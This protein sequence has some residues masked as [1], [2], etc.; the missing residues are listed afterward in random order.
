MT[1]EIYNQG[2]KYGAKPELYVMKVG[3]NMN[4]VQSRIKLPWD[5]VQ[6]FHDMAITKSYIILNS[7]PFGSKNMLALLLMLFGWNSLGNNLHWLEDEKS[8]FLVIDRQSLTL[9]ATIPTEPFSSYHYVN[10][11]DNPDGTIS[12][13]LARLR[14]HRDHLEDTFKDIFN[15]PF[16]SSTSSDVYRYELNPETSSVISASN[17][18]PNAHPM[19]FPVIHEKKVGQPFRYYF[20]PCSKEDGYFSGYQKVDI[21]TGDV[22]YYDLP[23]G[24]FGNEL[25]FI[26]S[27]ATGEREDEG[28]LV[29]HVYNGLH[30]RSEILVLDAKTMTKIALAPLP[31]HIPYTFHGI[32]ER[33]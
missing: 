6:M 26:S 32:F 20:S 11:Y 25:Q 5:G 2:Q 22:L 23:E 9:K 31:H 3:S 4:L 33:D 1:N 14:G 7:N 12:V 16:T 27:D 30:H 8:Y 10:A 29:T 18:S 19:E 28:Y 13:Y 24:T 21:S 17:V 15:K